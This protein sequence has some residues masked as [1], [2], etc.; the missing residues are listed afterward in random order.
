MIDGVDAGLFVYE[1]SGARSGGKSFGLERW[2]VEPGPREVQ[3]SVRDDGAE[4]VV[5]FEG[6]I[7]IP[8]DGAVTLVYEEA[9]GR[10]VER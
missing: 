1:P 2:W 10:F 7:D 4:W 6:T 9:E 3:F 5:A 8:V